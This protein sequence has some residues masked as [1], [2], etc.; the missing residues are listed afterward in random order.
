VGTGVADARA[1][2]DSVTAAVS[3]AAD[4]PSMERTADSVPGD[5]GTG[6][7]AADG[8]GGFSVAIDTADIDAMPNSCAHTHQKPQRR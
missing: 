6:V 3:A 1:G 7:T 4:L 8:N 2:D 5:G